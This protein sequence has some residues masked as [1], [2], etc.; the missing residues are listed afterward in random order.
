MKGLIMNYNE[1][2]KETRRICRDNGF[3]LG[4]HPKQI[5]NTTCFYFQDRSG[6]IILTEMTLN[7]A[8]YNAKNGTVDDLLFFEDE[9]DY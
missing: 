1:K 8:Y 2:L 3:V 5:G 4:K 7:E 9:K 6:E